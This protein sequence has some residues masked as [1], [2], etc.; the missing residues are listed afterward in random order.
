MGYSTIKSYA[1]VN[2]VLNIVGKSFSLHK[3]ESIISFIDL[4]DKILIKKIKQKNHKIKFTG[5]F[6]RS[7]TKNN[8]ITKPINGS[9]T[10]GNK[11][12]NISNLKGIEPLLNALKA[13]ALPL[14]YK[15]S[16]TNL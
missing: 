6:S 14:C 1:K 5:Q 11:V 2:L 7:I 13:T 16:Y 9:V 3:I 12:L 15:S 4:Y 10:N 8:T